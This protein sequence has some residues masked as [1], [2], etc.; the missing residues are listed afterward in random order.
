M[1]DFILNVTRFVRYS[2]KQKLISETGSRQSTILRIVTLMERVTLYYR[3]GKQKG[4]ARLRFRLMDGRKITLYHKTGYLAKIKDLEKYE[5]DGELKKRVEVYNK[6]LNGEIIRHMS[7]MHKAYEKMKEE[8]M[9]M[10]SEVF[11]REIQ[12]ALNPIVEVRTQLTETLCERFLRHEREALRDATTAMW[13]PSDLPASSIDSTQSKGKARSRPQN[14]QL[15]CCWSSV[16]SCLM[17]T[18]M[19]RDIN[20]C[21]PRAK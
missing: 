20:H 3:E 19:Y 17:N 18:F 1:G 13:K 14:S 10:T 7:A 8:G 4:V 16:R 21:T 11:E 12:A 6:E 9:D 2:P 15:T 5:N